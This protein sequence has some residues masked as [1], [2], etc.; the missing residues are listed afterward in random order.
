MLRF[1]SLAA[2]LTAA[3][4]AAAAAAAQVARYRG[5]AAGW[6]PIGAPRPL[7]EA[8]RLR[9]LAA[10]IAPEATLALR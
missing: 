5:S 9:A 6:Q 8:E 10:R 1:P 7:A 3:R 2:R 4:P